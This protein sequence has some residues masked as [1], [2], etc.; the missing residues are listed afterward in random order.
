MRGD[1]RN[2]VAGGAVLRP[3]VAL[4]VLVAGLVI[5]LHAQATLLA[6]TG[7]LRASFIATNPVQRRVDPKT[8]ATTGPAT[9]LTRELARPLGVPYLVTALPDSGSVLESVKSGK[10]DIV[11]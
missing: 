10:V 11:L 7:T 3:V 8:G 2:G 6:P 5:S 4:V 9:D 1:R